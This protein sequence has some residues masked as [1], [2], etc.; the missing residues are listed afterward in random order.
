MTAS[1]RGPTS[2]AG[3]LS[4]R[5]GGRRMKPDPRAPNRRGGTWWIRFRLLPPLARRSARRAPGPYSSTSSPSSASLLRFEDPV[6]AG[7]LTFSALHRLSTWSENQRHRSSQSHGL[8]CRPRRRDHSMF[9]SMDGRV[10]RI[11]VLDQGE[12]RLSCW[13]MMKLCD[14]T[15]SQRSIVH[16]QSKERSTMCAIL[17]SRV[18]APAVIAR[19][20]HHRAGSQR[21]VVP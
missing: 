18:R 11:K 9:G 7:L 17:L 2:A 14:Q 5:L 15:N 13:S 3:R 20:V 12:G 19:R 16:L 4:G 21:D 8:R 10:T 6:S 1:A